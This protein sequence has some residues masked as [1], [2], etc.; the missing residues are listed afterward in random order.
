M[1][2][3]M[4]RQYDKLQRLAFLRRQREAMAKAVAGVAK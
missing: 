3:Y 1:N 2:L 4:M